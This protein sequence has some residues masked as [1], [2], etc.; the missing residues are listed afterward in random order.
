MFKYIWKYSHLQTCWAPRSEI[1][2]SCGFS[3]R[4]E[5]VR[6]QRADLGSTKQ[7]RKIESWSP[8]KEKPT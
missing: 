6:G 5:H 8:G 4:L 7:G 3:A 1:Q 2:E